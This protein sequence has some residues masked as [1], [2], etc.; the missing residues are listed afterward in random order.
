MT[1]RRERDV[2]LVVADT[3]VRD[4][5]LVDRSLQRNR[6]GSPEGELWRMGA[7]APLAIV[8]AVTELAR[9]G[10]D[11]IEAGFACVSEWSFGVVEALARELRSDGPIVSAL[12]AVDGST[13]GVDRAWAAVRDAARP[14][15][16]VFTTNEHATDADGSPRPADA[17]LSETR[18]AVERARGYTADV[19]FSPLEADGDIAELVAAMVDVAVEAGA[20][21]INIRTCGT[22]ADYAATYRELLAELLRIAPVLRDVSLSADPFSRVYRGVEASDS[23]LACAQVAIDLG[24]RQIKC[25][26]HGTAATTGHVRMEELSL[27]A[28]SGSLATAPVRTRLDHRMLLA[29]S[30][31]IAAIKG[32]EVNPSD[33]F[34]GSELA[35]PS[36][37]DFSGFP[38]ERAEQAR[39]RAALLREL[40]QPIPD[41]LDKPP[42]EW[43]VDPLRGP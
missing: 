30:A 21:V 20:T 8:D 33:P 19:E 5:Y 32:Y 7:A 18:E 14:R 15:L 31:K 43:P 17:L 10:V 23:A 11:V 2:A 35:S 13:A 1:E 29:A 26:M 25:A 24:A 28:W 42:L 9:L 40:G 12:V 3:T 22:P 38:W 41:W 27:R 6:P 36:P 4:E 16:H 39:E 37:R 34:V